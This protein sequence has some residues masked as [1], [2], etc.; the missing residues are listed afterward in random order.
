[1]KNIGDQLLTKS[2]IELKLTW[3]EAFNAPSE[4]ISHARFFV[5]R[6]NSFSIWWQAKIL[7]EETTISKVTRQE[8]RNTLLELAKDFDQR[9]VIVD[10]GLVPVPLI[11]ASAY[12]SF[13]PLLEVAPALPEDI[14][15]T[16][17]PSP[18]KSMFGAG[19]LLLGLKTGDD[20]HSIDDATRLTIE[21]RVRQQF[22]ARIG[23]IEKDG[24]QYKAKAEGVPSSPSE[25]KIT[26]MPW[27]E[28]IPRL[29]LILGLEDL[30]VA[31]KAAE[32]LAEIAINEDFRQAIHKAGAVPHLVRM[33]GCGDEESME[34]AALSLDMLGKR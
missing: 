14:K 4:H 22:L 25:D 33:L 9:L 15:I 30:T 18:V 8:A 31:H 11:G 21:G 5:A 7:L 23:V 29:V 13:K 3:P 1:M 34:A 17:T 12:S 10:S 16:E 6:N 2:R 32:S 26:L 19:E 28:G 24:R 27:W 20:A